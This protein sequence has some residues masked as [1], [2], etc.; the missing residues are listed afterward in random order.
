MSDSCPRR[1]PNRLTA[2]NGSGHQEERSSGKV[3]RKSDVYG[4]DGMIGTG[5][6]VPYFAHTGHREA[7]HAFGM[8]S[9]WSRLNDGCRVAGIQSG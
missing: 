2:G 7:K 8:I 5:R 4:V 1:E 9:R 6:N 3:P